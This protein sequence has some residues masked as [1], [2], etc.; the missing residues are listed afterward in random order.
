M[1]VCGLI[2]EYNPFHNG[3]AYHIQEARRVSQAQVIVAIMS[4]S[5]LQR[6]EPAIIDKFHRAKAAL[7]SGVDIIIELPYLYAVQSSRLFAQG[8]VNTLF[9][10]G[11]TDLCF[12]SES[13]NIQDFISS[14]ELLLQQQD[15]YNHTLKN[16]LKQGESFPIASR[17]A[18]KKVGLDGATSIDLTKP[19]NILG[20]SYVR[21]ILDKQ[22]PIRPLTIKRIKS[23]YH[24]THIHSSIASATSIREAIITKRRSVR[25]VERTIPSATLDQMEQYKSETDIFHDWEN[26]FPLIHYRVMTMSPEELESILGVDEGLEYRLK[27]T[28]PHVTNFKDWMQ[29]MKTK[30]YTWTRLQRMF[31][32]I[33]TNTKKRELELIRDHVPYIRL[34]GMTKAGQQ[35]IRSR[36]KK[37]QVPL[38]TGI[39]GQ[40]HALL[41]V[42][43]RASAAYYSILSPTMRQQFLHQE[44]EKPIIR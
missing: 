13:G 33:L 37:L 44:L 6:G 26:Y 29:A 1:N 2:V 4:G 24:D 9:H 36:K 12:G 27:R 10:L 16:L 41:K 3:H 20:F 30:R 18:Y 42:E 11:I 15:T 17:E 43:E 31:V 34:L 28:A 23:D 21:E 22:L 39:G 32:H 7:Q 14:Y 19:N 8:A 40:V 35:Y 38:I 5:F 25:E